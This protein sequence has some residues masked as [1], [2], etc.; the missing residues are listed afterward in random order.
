MIECAAGLPLILHALQRDHPTVRVIS[1]FRDFIQR[2][3]LIAVKE[4]LF[5]F[6]VSRNTYHPLGAGEL[7]REILRFYEL[8]VDTS[9]FVG[10]NF[11]S[12]LCS[13]FVADRSDGQRIF[14][15]LEFPCWEGVTALFIA[16]DRN[17]H[18][19]AFGPGSN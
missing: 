18:V 11:R 4:S 2:M 6:F 9:C 19:R 3:A 15:W 5:L 8:D 7:R 10:F 12:R 17:R 1:A 16:D 13:E 14:S